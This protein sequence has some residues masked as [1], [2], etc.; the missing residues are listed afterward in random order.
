MDLGVQH[1]WSNKHKWVQINTIFACMW[2]NVHIMQAEKYQFFHAILLTIKGALETDKFRGSV[3]SVHDLCKENLTVVLRPLLA[4][5]LRTI[6]PS[7]ITTTKEK[8]QRQG[9][10]FAG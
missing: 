6:F 1:V 7:P 4:S 5:P 10:N 3:E 9:S 2:H 8:M